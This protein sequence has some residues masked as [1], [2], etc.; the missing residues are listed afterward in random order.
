[1]R[2]TRQQA[3]AWAREHMTG[4]WAAVPYPFTADGELDEAGLRHD[5]DHYCRVLRLD[6][7]FCGGLIGECWALALEER[8]RAQGIVM[9]AAGG[10]SQ[11]IAQ[12]GCSS[13]RDTIRLTRHAQEHGADFAVVMNPPMNPQDADTTVAFMRAV[14]AATDLGIALFNTS[15]SGYALAPET[16]ATLADVPN[17]VAVKDAQP[18]EHILATRRAVGGR[19]LVC[20]NREVRLLD[21]ALAHGDRVHMSSFSPLL[22]QW[23]GSLRVRDY[24]AAAVRGDLETARRLSAELEPIRQVQQRWIWDYTTTGR[25]AIGAIKHW[26]ALLGM[27]GGS[28]RPPLQDLTPDEKARLRADLAAAG[29]PV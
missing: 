3:K 1:M 26:C 16:I 10:R 24:L 8:E 29:V 11:V 2:Y 20:D 15:F 6:G 23:E 7:I 13:L 17:V 9:E 5:V 18:L 21:N 4:I 22:L 12:T 27:T 19:I 28:P 14:A 25:V